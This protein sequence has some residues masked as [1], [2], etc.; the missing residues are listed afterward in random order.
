MNQS[1]LWHDS[2]YDAVR[3]AVDAIGGPKKVGALLWPAKP[4]AEAQRRLLHCLDPERDHKLSLDEFEL[5]FVEARKA[6]CHTIAQYLA[7]HGYKVEPT[8]PRDEH[9]QLMHEYIAAVNRMEQLTKQM[10]R[11]QLRVA[12]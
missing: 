6:D 8:N 3:A 11:A 2:L 1:A 5:I 9:D 4:L 7:G 10:Q 12:E